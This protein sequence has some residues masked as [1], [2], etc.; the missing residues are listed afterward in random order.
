[1]ILSGKTIKYRLDELTRGSREELVNPASLNLRLGRSFKTIKKGQFIKLGEDVEYANLHCDGSD[2]ITIYPGEFMLATTMERLIIP[3]TMM[4]LVVGR[5][6]IARIGLSVEIAGD[7]DP[8]FDGHIT[9]ELYNES[10]N[11]IVL[12]PGYEICQVIFMECDQRCDPY[13]GKYNGQ[14]M[15]TESRMWKDRPIFEEANV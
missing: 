11:P 4:A 15:A 3:D 10:P 7:I 13:N 8:G 5:S 12:K 14:V 1:M 2:M 9:L 6:S